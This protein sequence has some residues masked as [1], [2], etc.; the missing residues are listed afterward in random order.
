MPI[1]TFAKLIFSLTLLGFA[2]AALAQGLSGGVP[3][4][5]IKNGTASA[6]PVAVIPFS[7]D[8][9]GLP[10]DTDVSGVIGDDLTTN[11]WTRRAKRV[12]FRRPSV[13]IA[14]K[15]SIYQA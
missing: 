10:P 2:G 4:I 8:G 7:F 9:A 14:K 5:N 15:I 13:R 6:I 12:I 1:R 11:F 3:T